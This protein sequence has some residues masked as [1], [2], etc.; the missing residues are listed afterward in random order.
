[1]PVI[2]ITQ[3]VPRTKRAS[4]FVRKM[5]DVLNKQG[6]I[7]PLQVRHLLGSDSMFTTFEQDAHGDDII[8]AARDLGWKTLLISV[9][10]KYEG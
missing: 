1:M 2:S 5:K 6:Q 3:L 9:M 4:I 8:H 10:Q 7:E